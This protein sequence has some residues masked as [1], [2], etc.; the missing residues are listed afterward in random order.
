M[1]AKPDCV[2]DLLRDL[3][4]GLND[5]LA[6]KGHIHLDR[7]TSA[8]LVMN[9]GKIADCARSLEN[10]WSCAE[11]NRR[12]FADRLKLIS[13]MT[14]VTAEVL[15]LMRPDIEDGGN[16]VQFRPKPSNSPA[17]SAPSGGDAA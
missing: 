8:R 6:T 1:T 9:V 7:A 12:A 14:A 5:E 17:P 15:Q 10:A 3:Y 4:R 2:S 11:W 13:D 16:V